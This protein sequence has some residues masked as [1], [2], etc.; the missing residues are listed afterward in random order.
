[1]KKRILV[2]GLNGL[3]G[4][5]V[6]IYFARQG[7]DI[8]GMDNNQRAAFFGPQGDTRWNQRRLIGTIP[9][10]QHHE[11]D[12]RDRQ[13]VL[14]ALKNIRPELVVHTAAQPSHD[15]A[16]AIDDFDTN[17]V[18]TLNLLEASRQSCPESPF[19]HMSTNKVYSD[20]PNTSP[21]GGCLKSGGVWVGTPLRRRPF[22]MACSGARRNCHAGGRLGKPSLP[23]C[24]RVTRL[25]RHALTESDT[26][27]DYAGTTFKHCIP[28]DF[29]IDQ[30][31]HSLYGASLEKP[32]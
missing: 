15:Q 14:A 18:G 9:D 19:V 13:S 1:M 25:F 29:P 10:F 7:C 12:I 28:E 32:V 3:I 16:A 8:H 17:A 31:L 24:L 22:G 6:C 30:S 11:L 2:T 20:R 26:R 4:S 5:E 21:L 23:G 27:R